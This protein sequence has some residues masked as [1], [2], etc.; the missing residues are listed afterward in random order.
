MGLGMQTPPAQ[1]LSGVFGSP[2]EPGQPEAGDSLSTGARDG[3]V[4]TDTDILPHV[5]TGLPT[6][7]KPSFDAVD[8]AHLDLASPTLRRLVRQES[9]DSK[10]Q[11]VA[12]GK[13]STGRDAS[14]HTKATPL[15][16]KIRGSFALVVLAGLLAYELTS[17]EWKDWRDRGEQHGLNGFTGPALLWALSALWALS[18]VLYCGLHCANASFRSFTAAQQLKAVKYLIQISWGSVIVVLY[19]VLQ[20]YFD[21]LLPSSCTNGGPVE[22]CAFVWAWPYT[23]IITLYGAMYVWELIHE[24]AEIHNSLAVHHL[25]IVVVWHL[26]AGYYA[27]R[28]DLDASQLK[29]I[30]DIGFPQLVAAGLEQPVFVALLMHRFG[31]KP[32]ART[33]AFQVAW[34]SFGASKVLALVLSVAVII[35]Q[36]SE[37]PPGFSLC[38]MVSLVVLVPT[39][40]YSTIVLRRLAHRMK[41]KGQHEMVNDTAA[42]AAA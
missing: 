13:D 28:L 30:G 17:F 31:S 1:Q 15:A 35:T 18:Q 24:G 4:T 21:G 9:E 10:P 36:W 26:A 27:T 19:V 14:K 5:I 3:M 32:S 16:C 7:G 38:M 20:L 39:Q 8:G 42:V 22:D 12:P 29:A 25:C 41:E 37:S 34:I 23:H 11:A 40:A 33:R 6:S 2:S